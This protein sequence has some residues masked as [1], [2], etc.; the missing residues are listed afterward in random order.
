[1]RAFFLWAGRSLEGWRVSAT[2]PLPECHRMLPMAAIH[3]CFEAT[4]CKNALD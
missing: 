2:G 4:R 3:A 1:M